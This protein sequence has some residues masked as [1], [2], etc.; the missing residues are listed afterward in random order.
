MSAIRFVFCGFDWCGSRLLVALLAVS[1]ASCGFLPRK[2]I[3]PTTDPKL[4]MP[5]N[6][7]GFAEM[8]DVRIDDDIFI[9]QPMERDEPLPD[10]NIE[11]F[12]LA[13]ATVVDVISTILAGTNISYTVSSEHPGANVLQ[14]NVVATDISGN[15]KS[16]LDDFSASAGFCYQ[17]S[18]GVLRI[19]LDRQFIAKIPPVNE[20]FDSLPLMLKTLGATDAFV[21][22]TSRVVTYRASR[23]VQDKVA[24]YL[25]WVRDN[26]KMIVYETYITEV[27]LSDANNA[28]IQW[29][30]LTTSQ[31]ASTFSLAG[32]VADTAATGSVGIGAVF[33]GQFS[34]DVLA[35]FLR[36]QGSAK[37]LSRIPMMLISGG[38]ATFHNGG[39]DF[40]ISGMGA[41]TSTVGGQIIPGQL[42][43]SQLKSGIDLTLAG[44]IYDDTV[45]TR[46][47]ISMNTLTGYKSFPAGQ[48]QVFLAPVTTDRVVGTSVRVHPGE[49]ILIAGINYES[50]SSN[51]TGVPGVGDSLLL[52]TGKATSATRNELVIVMKPKIVEFNIGRATPIVKSE[53]PVPVVN[54]KKIVETHADSWSLTPGGMK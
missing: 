39:V 26:K 42:Q 35:A 19:S 1:L 33:N 3:V 28:G 9:A 31:G 25:K 34:A 44:D 32:G 37:Q 21:D 22:K 40:Y 2:E 36:T 30:K 18:R 10:V 38:Q 50:F 4:T 5:K 47:D 29:N 53:A 15:L 8:P 13:N 45:F 52:R 17:Y 20:L 51:D 7:V 54:E 46:I 12:T 24:S 48:G 23:P 43:L 41:P 49:T 27:A 14:R 6:V 11:S 16:V